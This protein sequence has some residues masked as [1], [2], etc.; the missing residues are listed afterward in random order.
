MHRT[1]NRVGIVGAMLAAGVAR[2]AVASGLDAGEGKIS[3]SHD[4]GGVPYL[5]MFP[6]QP[7][8]TPKISGRPPVGWRKEQS[9]RRHRKLAAKRRANRRA[10]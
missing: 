5:N 9:L 2:L 4:F 1:S 8:H 6:T 3:A 7:R 10:W